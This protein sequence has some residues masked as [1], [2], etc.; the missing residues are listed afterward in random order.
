MCCVAVTF[1]LF[2]ENRVAQ[3]LECTLLILFTDKEGDIVVGAAI[4]D[5]TY[6]NILHGIERQGFETYV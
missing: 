1:L 2:I 6:R 5:H 4:A 3:T